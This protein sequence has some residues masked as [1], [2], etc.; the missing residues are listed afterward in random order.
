MCVVH[1]KEGGEGT[2]S[3]AVGI[4]QQILARDREEHILLFLL[5]RWDDVHLT[6]DIRGVLV[7]A[8]ITHH[9]ILGEAIDKGFHPSEGVVERD[10]N[11]EI[12][13]HRPLAMLEMVSE[14]LLHLLVNVSA[15]AVLLQVFYDLL[16]TLADHH[17]ICEEGAHVRGNASLAI[18]DVHCVVSVLPSAL[19]DTPSAVARE[20]LR[21]V[22]AH[23]VDAG[24][25]RAFNVC[26]AAERA[27]HNSRPALAALECPPPHP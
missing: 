7:K 27:A 15:E 22:L 12:H 23:D 21:P 10:I 11:P 1:A 25:P 6:K 19:V 16:W 26:A 9:R 18:S 13:L 24:N 17:V 5:L 8:G 14:P 2:Y 3:L 4:E 20:C